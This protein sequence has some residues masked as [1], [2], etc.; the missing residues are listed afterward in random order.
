MTITPAGGTVTLSSLTLNPTSVSGGNNSTGTVTLTWRGALWRC[1]CHA[2]EQQHLC[3][4]GS[5][6]RHSVSGANQCQ[7]YREN[8]TGV[9]EHQ[10]RHL[11]HLQRN[12]QAGHLDRDLGPALRVGVKR[13]SG[14]GCPPDTMW[15]LVE[16][17]R[18]TFVENAKACRVRDRA[19]SCSPHPQSWSAAGGLPV[20]R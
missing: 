13:D 3:G 8:S 7:L 20:R 18:Q 5:V 12:D 19:V 17:W 15:A 1:G 10:C 4:H 6:Q 16:V 2:L 11:G 14:A 9:F